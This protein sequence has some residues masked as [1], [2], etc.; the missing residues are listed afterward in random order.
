MRDLGLLSLRLTVGGLM[1]GHGAQKL[2][3]WFG[4]YG[5][6]GTGGWLE[7]LGFRPGEQWAKA[8]GAAEFGS[9]TLTALGL[10]HPIGPMTM[11]GPMTM[12]I[13]KVH[14]GKPIWVTEGG[15]E[16]PVTNIAIAV[17]LMLTGPG[18]FSLDALFG[19][20]LPWFVVGLA[21]GATGAGIWMGM[22]TTQEPAQPAQQTQSEAGSEAQG[23]QGAA[24]SAASG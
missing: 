19:I 11:L 24:T 5:V 17:A 10:M 14:A 20:R 16:L 9:G 4:G 2:F 21:A 12:A 7:S 15:A 13:T 6:Q 18:R 3:G 1:A 22:K 8:A 23:G